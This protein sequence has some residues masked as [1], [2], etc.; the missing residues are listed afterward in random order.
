MGLA[1]QQG[2]LAPGAMGQFLVA[3]HLAPRHHVV[4]HG[5]DRKVT[6]REAAGGRRPG[7]PT[8]HAPSARG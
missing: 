7:A 3:Q 4:P 5:P 2:P 6:L 1:W 8:P